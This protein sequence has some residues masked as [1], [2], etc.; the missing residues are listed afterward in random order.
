[1]D[2]SYFGALCPETDDRGT[3]WFF[4]TKK[5]RKQSDAISD[6]SKHGREA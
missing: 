3:G 2:D 5:P 1:M 6:E 4:G